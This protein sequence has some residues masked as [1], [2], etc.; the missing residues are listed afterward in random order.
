MAQLPPIQI[1]STHAHSDMEAPQS[2]ITTPTK[3]AHGLST[4]PSEGEKRHSTIDQVVDLLIIISRH[5]IPSTNPFEVFRV[6]VADFRE[7]KKRCE[8]QGLDLYSES[9]RCVAP[10]DL[11]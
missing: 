2:Q 5:S 6:E 3:F 8:Q 10:I 11:N 9:L 1:G 4:P 7:I